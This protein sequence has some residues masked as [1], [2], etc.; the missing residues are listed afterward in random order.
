ML[1]VTLYVHEEVVGCI[2]GNRGVWCIDVLDKYQNHG[3]GEALLIEFCKH[4]PK[5]ME[6]FAD[7]S[8]KAMIR[9]FEKCGF[10]LK[11]DD[12]DDECSYTYVLN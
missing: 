9:V 12:E 7:R 6:G 4:F 2:E 5:P 1:K 10:K 11:E 8:N 3:H